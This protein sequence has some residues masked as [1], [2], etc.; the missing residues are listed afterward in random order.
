MP[1]TRLWSF[2]EVS[3]NFGDVNPDTTEINILML[4]EFGL[5]Y[6]NDWYLLP[7]TLLAGSIYF[8]Y[9]GRVGAALTAL[10]FNFDVSR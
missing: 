4:I 7:V 3:T 10:G 8:S 9:D 1:H 2:E 6:A 5:V